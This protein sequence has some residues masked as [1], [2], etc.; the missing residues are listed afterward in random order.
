MTRKRCVKLLMAKGYDR[1]TANAIAAEAVVA[2]GSYAKGFEQTM[3]IK[4]AIENLNVSALL[5]VIEKFCTTVAEASA[6]FVQTFKEAYS[7]SDNGMS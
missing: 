3:N 2:Y 7:D 6:A 1:N 5:D 4:S